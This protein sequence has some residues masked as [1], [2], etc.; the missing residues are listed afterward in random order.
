MQGLTKNWVG[1]SLSQ[2][3]GVRTLT[4]LVMG[5]LLSLIPYPTVAALLSSVVIPLNEEDITEKPGSEPKHEDASPIAH[6]ARQMPPRDRKILES[7]CRQF[8]Q[9]DALS[10]VACPAIPRIEIRNGPG[11][12]LHC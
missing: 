1:L 12:S 6:R 4:A 8:Q 10:C 9:C 5:L 7:A 2:G 11:I 3:Q